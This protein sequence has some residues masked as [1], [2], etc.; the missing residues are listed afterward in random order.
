MNNLVD[1]T[2]W[3]LF[4]V[5]NFFNMKAGKY[6]AKDDYGVGGTPLVSSS[7]QNNGIMTYTDL[8]PAFENGIT[9]GKVNMSVFYQERPFCASPDV[10]V[11]S[12]KN[13]MSKNVNLFFVAMLLCE[14]YRFNYGNQIRL[15]DA[16]KLQ[17]KLPAKNGE[18]DWEFM[19]QFICERTPDYSYATKPVE[20]EP[21]PELNVADWKFYKL[22]DLFYIKYGVNLELVNLEE[23]TRDYKGKVRFVSRI[24][25]N[26]GVSAFVKPEEG[27]LPNLANTISVAGGGSV[28]AAFLQTGEYYSGRDI[29]CLQPK[30]KIDNLTVLFLTTL[31][32][33]EKYRYNYGRQANKTLRTLKI[34]LPTKNGEPDWDFMTN[35]VR[36]LPFSSQVL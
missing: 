19:E 8:E 29:Y 34:K 21:T 35:F 6:Y 3:Q 25:N 26:N 7:N 31:I 10:T 32:S 17:V 27:K 1:T 13:K 23:A 24:A 14:R 5:S 30:K 22:E 33:K 15:N 9:I 28:L 2:G 36:T 11:L 18:P 20:N 4:A 12:P 16:L